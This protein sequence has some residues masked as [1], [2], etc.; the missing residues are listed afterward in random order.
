MLG[1][2]HSTHIPS[3]KP[4]SYVARGECFRLTACF[5]ESSKGKPPGTGRKRV[6]GFRP[7]GTHADHPIERGALPFSEARRRCGRWSLRRNRG[8]VGDRFP[9]SGSPDQFTKMVGAFEQGLKEKSYIDGL[10]VTRRT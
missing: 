2:I 6:T 10:N 5:G 1:S 4:P 3:G 9:H 7:R 8:N